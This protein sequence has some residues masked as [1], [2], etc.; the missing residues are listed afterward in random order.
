MVQ[1]PG[2]VALY[3]HGLTDITNW[4]RNYTTERCVSKYDFATGTSSI[5]TIP[6]HCSR[7]L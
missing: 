7:S 5:G 1:G 2:M 3:V 6:A 4:L